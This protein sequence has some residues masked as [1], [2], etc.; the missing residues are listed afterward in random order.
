[1][2]NKYVS[3]IAAVLIGA[4][5][6]AWSADYTVI[7]V[8]NSG[9]GSLRQALTDANVNPGLDRVLFNIPGS[10]LQVI[11]V[12]AAL[13]IVTD[14]VEIDGYSQPGSRPNELADADNA[15]RFIELLGTGNA[16]EGLTLAAGNSIVNGLALR[17]FGS[18]VRVQ[19]SSNHLTGNFIGSNERNFT[20]G[21][22][23]GVL[24]VSHC[25]NTIG[26]VEPEH[27]NVMAGNGGSSIRITPATTSVVTSN[28]SV[29]GNFLGVMSDGKTVSAYEAS[30]GVAI[31]Q[32]VNTVIGGSQPGASS[33]SDLGCF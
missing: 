22:L 25:C 13:P 19:S 30:S 2:G 9:A 27:R 10:G 20:S 12:T 3:A 31:E 28:N 6:G 29:L 26:G 11:R 24:V 5:V 4:T 14:P 16:V 32:S 18:G 8:N 23:I 21:N 17:G 1:M 7:N 15:V 33:L